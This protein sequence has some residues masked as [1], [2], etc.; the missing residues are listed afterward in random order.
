M[1]DEFRRHPD[2]SIDFDF[3]R[4]RATTLRRQA[5]RGACTLRTTSAGALVMAGALGFAVVIPSVATPMRDRLAAAWPS[6][7][8]TR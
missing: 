7:T 1:I 3:Y 8:R 5:M 2:G 6:S 4:A